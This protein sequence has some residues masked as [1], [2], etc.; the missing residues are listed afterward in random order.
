MAQEQIC[1][2]NNLNTDLEEDLRSLSLILIP[3]SDYETDYGPSSS[4]SG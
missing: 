3:E 2:S 4:V 1:W